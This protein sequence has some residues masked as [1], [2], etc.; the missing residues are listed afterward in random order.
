M[1]ID[2]IVGAVKHNFFESNNPEAI[3]NMKK[4]TEG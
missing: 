2:N 4:F 3:K 1:L